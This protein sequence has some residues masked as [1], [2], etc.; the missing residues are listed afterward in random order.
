MVSGYDNLDLMLINSTEI[1]L[2]RELAKRCMR[3]FVEMA[4]PTVEPAKEYI[5]SWH[6]DAVCDHLQAV[7]EGYINR[8]VINE[9]PGS[10]KSLS[11]CVFFP[12]WVWALEARKKFIFG[13]YADS[14]VLR[15][16][17][18]AR[19]LIGSDWYQQRWGDDFKIIPGEDTAS[20]YTNDKGGFRVS[21]TVKGGVTGEHA[22]IQVV[23]DPIKPLEVTKSMHV[24]KTTLDECDV[25]WDETMSSRLV[26]FEK[27]ARI[28]I[29]QRLHEADLAGKA[30]E[31]GYVHLMLPMEYEPKRKCFTCIGFEDP[32][33]EEGELLCPERFSKEAVA[34][35]K[36]GLG[37]ARAR[38]AQLQQNPTPAEGSIIKL[39]WARFYQHLP[40][41]NIMIQS[42][43]C[44]FKDTEGTDFVVGQVWGMV[45]EQ[46]YLVDQIRARMNFTDT[47]NAI[48]SLTTKWPKARYKIVEDKANGPAVIDHLK[49]TVSGLKA[50]NPEGGKI[51][52][53]HAIEPMWESG[54]VYLPDP[55]NAPWVD[56]PDSFL[57]EVTGFPARA[58]DDQV[59]A[60]S[61]ALIFLQTK[62]IGRL[63]QA[64]QNVMR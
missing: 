4:W 31:R 41:F 35:I 10:T 40:T 30:I 3:D 64:M 42:W 7:Y 15:D 33:T 13:S 27:S 18:R 53:V 17:R 8:L 25:W 24:A 34:E 23:D 56:G 62:R 48:K 36:K 50:V 60:M 46:Y 49:S 11:C 14:V 39:E 57:E 54:N 5:P 28:I 29:M 63:K 51:A 6:V 1:S 21:T 47:C 58:H 59:D 43:D 2:D 32:R 12:A 55:E 20:R 37:T 61:Q 26:D 38:S 16:A 45:R 19:R 44:T 9:P 52:R 22:D